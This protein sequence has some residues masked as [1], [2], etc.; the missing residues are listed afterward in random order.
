MFKVVLLAV[1]GLV[2]APVALPKADAALRSR[3]QAPAEVLPV[4]DA[5]PL[6]VADGPLP[7]GCCRPVCVKYR[8]KTHRRV[9]C[10]PCTPDINTTVVV[11]D[12]CTG[13]PQAI[14][15]CLPGCC[16]GCPKITDHCTLFGRGA[17]TYCWECGFSVTF[18][19]QRN[20]DVLV[21]YRS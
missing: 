9:C 17:I 7:A 16:V 2:V 15:V 14:D 5:A 20:G 3:G 10:D 21:T 18:R 13:Y 6:V 11:C 4:P 8:D 12:P 19:F 1:V